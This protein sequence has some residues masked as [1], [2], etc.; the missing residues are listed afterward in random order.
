MRRRR[1][2]RPE[3]CEEHNAEAG[4]A[5]PQ[6]RSG[7]CHCFACS[8]RLA[9]RAAGSAGIAC[10]PPPQLG[11]PWLACC[12][13]TA[14][15]HPR[16]Q[17]MYITTIITAL[18][19]ECTERGVSIH[20]RTGGVVLLMY[21]TSCREAGMRRGLCKGSRQGRMQGFMQGFKRGFLQ[22]KSCQ[23]RHG[24]WCWF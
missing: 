7:H 23:N 6:L 11:P 4:F 15:P 12:G 9:W 20:V 3:V 2:R 14:Y 19:N 10:L 1:S 24:L 13:G 22:G 16:Q 5:L 18:P 8:A 21:I 17:I